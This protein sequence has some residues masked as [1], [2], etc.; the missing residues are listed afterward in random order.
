MKRNRSRGGFLRIGSDHTVKQRRVNGDQRMR[1]AIAA[2]ARGEIVP[3][4]GKALSGASIRILLTRQ[5]G[6]RFGKDRY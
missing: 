6:L 1:Q 5:M 4:K 3:R 2:G